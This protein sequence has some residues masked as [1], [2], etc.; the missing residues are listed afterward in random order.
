MS[1]RRR[2]LLAPL[3]VTIAVH[4]A[5]LGAQAG[6]A[7]VTGSVAIGANALH[8]GIDSVIH[9]VALIG[10]VVATRPPNERHP[11]G[12][13]RVEAV[14]S[15]VIGLLL[16]V[17]VVL[18][19]AAA[20]PRL[21]DPLPARSIDIGL[22]VMSVSAIATGSLAY[23]LSRSGRR[24]ASRI[25]HS[26][27]VHTLADTLTTIGVLAAVALTAAGLP[28]FDPIVALAVAAVVGWR[29][30]RVVRGAVDVLTDAAPIDAAR[31]RDAATSVRGVV[32]CHAIRSRGDRSHLTAE[33]HIHVPPDMTVAE[34]HRVAKAVESQVKRAD[35]A[36]VEVFVHVGAAADDDAERHTRGA[37]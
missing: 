14:T 3:L 12:Y 24:L 10:A 2:A 32:D 13:D 22:A 7:I 26:E 28:L 20:I 25:V 29:G 37:R 34:S 4:L 27:S 30:S 17:V 36:V 15:F 8:L 16:L 5:L 23:Y 9:A 6:A 19:A 21:F 33:L 11:Y 31:I 1:D 35:A 18:I